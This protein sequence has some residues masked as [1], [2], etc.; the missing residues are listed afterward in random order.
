MDELSQGVFDIETQKIIL[1]PRP[2]WSNS[3]L[4]KTNLFTDNQVIFSYH[5]YKEYKVFRFI[6][7]E[8]EFQKYH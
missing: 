6:N 1:T 2:D 8:Y 7:S 3:F 4:L 5:K